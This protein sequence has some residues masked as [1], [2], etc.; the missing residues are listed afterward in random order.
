MAFTV[1][2]LEGAA[3]TFREIEA[4]ARK[5]LETRTKSNKAKTSGQEGLFKQIVPF[6]RAVERNINEQEIRDAGAA[7]ELVEEYPDDK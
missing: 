5:S 1:V 6:R 4:A 3:D 7:A 2:W